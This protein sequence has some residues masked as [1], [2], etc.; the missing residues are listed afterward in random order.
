MEVEVIQRESSDD[1]GEVRAG[2]L[3]VRQ[4]IVYVKQW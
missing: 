2:N 4:S 1:D 3:V